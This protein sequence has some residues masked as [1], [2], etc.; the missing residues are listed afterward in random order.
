MCVLGAVERNCLDTT[1][2]GAPR[3]RAAAD[4]G[5]GKRDFLLLFFNPSYHTTY[6]TQSERRAQESPSRLSLRTEEQV[7]AK[8]AVYV[9]K[10]INRSHTQ[11]HNKNNTTHDPTRTPPQTTT[12]RTT[13]PHLTTIE[14]GAATVRT[15]S[16]TRVGGRAEV[17]LRL[18]VK[19]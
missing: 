4:G 13:P 15:T 8:A 1:S 5:A 14:G 2:R 17:S 18:R 3:A 6:T 11:T 9:C 12:R 7:S 16:H 10:K 19:G